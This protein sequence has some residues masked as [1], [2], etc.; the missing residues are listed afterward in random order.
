[1]KNIFNRLHKRGY[2]NIGLCKNL[3]ISESV[4]KAYKRRA[5]NL[6]SGIQNKLNDLLCESGK[7]KKID[8]QGIVT[9]RNSVNKMMDKFLR[10]L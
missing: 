6:P 4:L 9:F 3:G 1:M 7:L 10:R 5:N 8:L 2:S